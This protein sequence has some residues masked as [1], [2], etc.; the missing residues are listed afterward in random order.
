MLGVL[1]GLAFQQIV[2]WGAYFIQEKAYK[3]RDDYVRWLIVSVV[4]SLILLV[5]A[6]GLAQFFVW[7]S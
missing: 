7:A 1:V 6:C 5:L 4:S 3:G 2:F